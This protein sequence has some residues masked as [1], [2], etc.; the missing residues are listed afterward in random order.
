[1]HT[2]LAN[3][4]LTADVTQERSVAEGIMTTLTERKFD[5]A[6]AYLLQGRFVEVFTFDWQTAS[7]SGELLAAA[8]SV[9]QT[10]ITWPS[11]SGDEQ[12]MPYASD[13]TR[14]ES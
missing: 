11:V 7:F 8:S 6:L 3:Y 10:D 14:E 12:Y 1:L 4:P 13:D 9:A 2:V 5:R